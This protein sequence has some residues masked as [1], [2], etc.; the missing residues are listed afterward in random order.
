MFTILLFS[1][2]IYRSGT[3][4]NSLGF[5][6]LILLVWRPND[7]FTSSFQLTFVS[8]GAI[9]AIAFPLVAKLRSIGDWSPSVEA[10]FPPRVAVWLKRFCETLYWREAIWERENSR[11]LWT[12]NLFKS[13]YLKWLEAKN[14]QT[15]AR[16]IFEALLVST[17]MQICLLPLTIIYFHRLSVLSVF[18]NLWVGIVIAF[19]SF[20]AIIAVF[21]ANINRTIALPIIK[22]TEL[23]NWLLVS[24]PNFLTQNSW[25][26]LR[27]PTYSGAMRAIYILYFVPVL[28]LAFALNRWKPFNAPIAESKTSNSIFSAPVLLRS[29]AALLSLLDALVIFHP[30]SSP[31]IDG[32]L[33]VDFLDVGHG[34]AALV[35]FPNGETLLVDGGGKANFNQTNVG[36]KE[37]PEFFEPD[38]RNIGEAVVSEF[39]WRRGYSQIDYILATHADADHIQGLSDV[40]SNFRIQTAIFGRTPAKDAEFTAL[41]SVLLKDGI[42]SATLSRGDVLTFGDVKI[43]ILY[44][45]RD[46]SPEA[47]SDN[48]HSLVLRLVYG[49]R[50]FLLTG[51]V[52]KETESELTDAPEFLQTDVIK[53]AH[54]GSRTSSVQEFINASKA[55]L[56][57]VSVGTESP[58]GHPHQEVVERWKDSGAKVLTTGEN[59]TIS[60]S[61][62]GQ[63]LQLK[64]FKQGKIYR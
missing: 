32:R 59:G 50:K 31:K 9:V 10:P 38:T 24:V 2:V 30:F 44:P 3:L 51:D 26:N 57:I 4:L 21:L 52:E 54:H 49:D 36:T 8:V 62:D 34:D 17:V 63:D 60:V 48:N 27:L 19:E 33:H 20:A 58:Y 12:A 39:L 11:Q 1:Q 6:A 29:A 55:K 41:D 40:A 14:L 15:I 5:C 22:L 64:V 61:T 25:A 56:A 35:T 28:F 47:I 23:L 42:E 37:E 18:L 16:Y 43:E 13:S 45:L 53:V 46:D 7:I